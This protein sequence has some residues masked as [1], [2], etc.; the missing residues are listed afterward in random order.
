MLD[1]FASLAL[2][3]ALLS[4]TSISLAF[5]SRRQQY[6]PGKPARNPDKDRCQELQAP[7]KTEPAYHNAPA[8]EPLPMT[9]EPAP[10]AN[11][12]SAFVAYSLARKIR[13]L[14]YQE[15]CYCGCDKF[16]DHKSLLDCFTTKHGIGCHICQRGV[17]FTH[18]QA[19]TGKTAAQIRDAMAKGDLAGFDRNKYVDE[20]Y[21]QH[22]KSAP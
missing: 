15:P 4:A 9:L 11:N 7:A 12:R 14:L 13:G 2:L 5:S 20:H 22:K 21:D 8:T 16:S 18:E 3:L 10:F 6:T 1:R 17:M 19:K